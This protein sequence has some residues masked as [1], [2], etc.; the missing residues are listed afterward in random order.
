MPEWLERLVWRHAGVEYVP[1]LVCV[2][3]AVVVW[4]LQWVCGRNKAGK[5]RSVRVG[6][7]PGVA[8]VVLVV[9]G[10]A[11]C[12][13]TTGL[14]AQAWWLIQDDPWLAAWWVV[15]VG[16]AA[17][18]WGVGVHAWR[19]E[20]RLARQC[21]C[22]YDMTVVVGMRCPECGRVALSERRLRPFNVR[23]WAIWCGVLV[24]AGGL[25]L[26]TGIAVLRRGPAA[27]LPGR[28]L[29]WWMTA[30][31]NPPPAVA[32]EVMYRGGQDRVWWDEQIGKRSAALAERMMECGPVARSDYAGLFSQWGLQDPRNRPAAEVALTNIKSA[33]PVRRRNAAALLAEMGVSVAPLSVV[34]ELLQDPDPA[35]QANGR[36][37]I[38]GALPEIVKRLAGLDGKPPESD[39]KRV[40]TLV[41]LLCDTQAMYGEPDHLDAVCGSADPEIAARGAL[42]RNR[43]L[44]WSR[45]G[46]PEALR[47][48]LLG[49]RTLRDLKQPPVVGGVSM[50]SFLWGADLVRPLAVLLEDPDPVVR[51]ELLSELDTTTTLM[52]GNFV[53]GN[54]E[55][56]APLSDPMKARLGHEADPEMKRLLEKLV[57]RTQGEPEPARTP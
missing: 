10:V 26:P 13:V 3:A 41:L 9:V 39:P 36:A 49:A 24:V 51:R 29:L 19:G 15:G 30:T 54:R 35:T 45:K 22:G 38:I 31:S 23:R 33:N 55:Y 17:G 37:L 20:T 48:A 46:T 47:A 16:V 44:S 1:V 40:R 14:G 50:Q 8:V 28:M 11:A 5:A 2:G 43:S 32:R 52:A 34:E 12:A 7:G 21:R 25:L 6:W 53:P 4:Y 56:W 42:V 27:A 57:A 18:A